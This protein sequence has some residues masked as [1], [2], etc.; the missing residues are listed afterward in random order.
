MRLTLFRIFYTR[1]LVAGPSFKGPG[2]SAIRVDGF[3]SRNM[4]KFTEP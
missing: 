1:R 3:Y 2:N 4:E